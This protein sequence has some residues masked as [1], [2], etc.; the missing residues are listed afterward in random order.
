MLSTLFAGGDELTRTT[1]P[2]TQ[3]RKQGMTA[4]LLHQRHLN[5]VPSRDP[6]CR[7]A[8]RVGQT[9]TASTTPGPG[10]GL[11]F[12]E[13]KDASRRTIDLPQRAIEALRTHRKRQL[14][15]KL[16]AGSYEDSD[17]VFATGKG[18]PL[19][20]QN[21]VNRHFKPLLRRAALPIYSLARPQ[22]H[23]RYFPFGA[24]RPP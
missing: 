16:K 3:S 10:G 12:S 14:E 24:R 15:E 2:C 22:A 17:V 13:P 9:G 19:D 4:Q 5:L 20:A 8:V 18:T 21:I 23:V 1:P 7:L 6:V 11:V